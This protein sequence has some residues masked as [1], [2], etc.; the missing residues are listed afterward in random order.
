MEK[1]VVMGLGHLDCVPQYQRA[2]YR[3][4]APESPFQAYQLHF[5]EQLPLPHL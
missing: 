1:N 2:E 5:L 4:Q 3:E